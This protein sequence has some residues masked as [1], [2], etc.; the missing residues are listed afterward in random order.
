MDYWHGKCH[1][2]P[3]MRWLQEFGFDK[4]L[5]E[6]PNQKWVCG[7]ARDGHCCLAG[8]DAHGNCTATT[9][10]R[11]LRKGDHWHCT[12]PSTLG[13]PC[14]EGPLPDGRCCREIP[15][16]SP[17]RS[18]RSLRGI[19]VLMVVG[20]TLASLVMCLGSKY[21]QRL[22]SPGELSFAHGSADCYK[23]HGPLQASAASWLPT[24][25]IPSSAH[26]NSVLCLKC[27]NVGEAPFQPHS[28][29]TQHLH[30]LTLASLKQNS[31]AR[32]PARFALVSFIS[33]VGH[34][35]ESDIA[36]ATCHKEH[37]GREADIK[38]ITDSQ[39]Q[40]CH[41]TQFASFAEGHPSFTRY[42]FYRRTRI[43]FDH[44]S[45][46][47]GHFAEPA[48][49]KFAPG[50]CLDC[51]QTDPRGGAML[52]KPFEV[53]CA[54]CHG[55]QIKGKSAV[56]PGIPIISIP[57]MD[58]Q[59]LSGDYSIGEWP[60]DADQPLGP[61][62]RL[63]LSGDPQLRAAMD[64]LQAA[65]LS[66]LPKT[67]PKKLKAAQTLAWGIKSLIFDLGTRG[68]DEWIKRIDLGLGRTLTSSEQEGVTAFLSAD[69]LQAAFQSS[70]PHLQQ[71]VLAY[72]KDSSHSPTQLVPSP[73]LAS[74]STV[75]AAS[76]DAW[77]SQGGWYSLDGTFT[78][79]Y[80]PRGHADRFLSSWMNLTVD[81]SHTAD[82]ADSQAF[83]N[84]LSTPT[85]AG[86]CSKCHSID[87][88]P[89][90]QVNWTSRPDTLEHGFNRFSHMAHLSLL[91][92]TGCLKC[93]PMKMNE[94][95]A[96]D[97]YASAFAPGK[98]DASIFHS[99]FQMIDKS[100]C[101]SCHQPNRVREDCLLCHNYHIG[102]FKPVVANASIATAISPESN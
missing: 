80:H 59:R 67:D 63:L 35:G 3:V 95:N 34:G 41:A 97:S 84:I 71:E 66:N 37:Q 40:N 65:D 13:G 2:V 73:P 9:E 76:P 28:L 87:D 85:T 93:H 32:E 70:F 48:V 91:D 31:A 94:N 89:A 45:H 43:I 99:N 15:R 29:S 62:L 44:Q 78:L 20:A 74:P 24:A 101:A 75:K 98:H 38:K 64:E 7:R 54:S 47:R 50:T 81:A 4:S 19:T 69:T 46:L 23:C 92:M 39:C 79:S 25:A 55:D 21:G 86:L 88:T 8:P 1:E 68:Q 14:A 51:H 49:A 10:C 96:A 83:F 82:P 100:V 90:R 6:R 60:E 53:V 26:D 17:V 52:V 42:P 27:H 18:V 33:S 5:Y 102:R 11:P 56:T 36:C 12:R 61:F 58:D 16:C 77:V 30:L 57:R 72:R 22:F